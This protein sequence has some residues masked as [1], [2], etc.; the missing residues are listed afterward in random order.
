MPKCSK[1]QVLEVRLP[2]THTH[3]EKDRQT[4]RSHRSAPENVLLQTKRTLNELVAY[5]L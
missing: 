1:Q 2:H 4:H 5:K 3:R